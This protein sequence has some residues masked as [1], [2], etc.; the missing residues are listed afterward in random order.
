MKLSSRST[1]TAYMVT[2]GMLL[3][4]LGLFL[5]QAGQ[6]PLTAVFFRCLFGG[7]ALLVY[8]FLAR[9]GAEL[10]PTARGL[11]IAVLTGLLMTTM[12]GSFFMAIQWTS[13]AAATV[14]FHLQPF[15]VLLAGAW[16]LGEG[17]SKARAA[18]VGA[19]MLGLALATGLWPGGW[20]SDQ[21][22]FAWGLGLAVFGSV[23]YAVVSLVAKQQR[24]ISAL[25]LT[26]WQCGVGCLLL[27]WW[28]WAQDIPT[29]AATWPWP[30]WAWLA[31]LGLVHTG[32]AYPLMYAGMQRL[33]AGRIA[34][35]QF[36]YP[37]AAI[38]LDA[39]VYGHR[40]ST[41]QWAGV[42]LMGAALWW[43]ERGPVTGRGQVLPFATAVGFDA[44]QAKG[45]T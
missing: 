38:V 30:T 3:G 35:L 18:A 42:V 20:P 44:Q 24:S 23:C 37:I 45:K 8:A 22:L 43:A 2:G 11:G 31:G 5:E 9:R 17:L 25:G 7:S 34:V 13:I 10:R 41:V 33:D 6:H 12:W 21:P 14:A 28:P 27:L 15:W 26:F 40:L 1:G 4:T 29:Q 32:L 36:V 39:T 16:L 19:A